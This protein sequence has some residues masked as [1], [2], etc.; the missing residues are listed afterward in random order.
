ME[1]TTSRYIDGLPI[2]TVRQIEHDTEGLLRQHDVDIRGT[3]NAL[4]SAQL[5]ASGPKCQFM[6]RR[7]NGVAMF[8][9][10]E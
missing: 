10:M 4:S 2:G 3:L 6:S 7:W 1:D 5:V 8:C 9:E